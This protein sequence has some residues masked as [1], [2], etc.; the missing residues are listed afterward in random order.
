MTVNQRTSPVPVN[1]RANWGDFQNS[2]FYWPISVQ[3]V[4][5]FESREIQRVFI[6]IFESQLIDLDNEFGIDFYLFDLLRGNRHYG[7]AT[8][9]HAES[10]AHLNFHTVRRARSDIQGVDLS[11]RTLISPG[12]AFGSV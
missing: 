11:T 4:G 5:E 1:Q 9:P 3:R 12:M 6:L 2:L 7:L 10:S 8:L